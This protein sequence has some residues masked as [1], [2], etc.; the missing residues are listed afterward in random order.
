MAPLK[1]QKKDL[2]LKCFIWYWTIEMD[3]VQTMKERPSPKVL[4]GAKTIKLIGSSFRR[5]AHY[6]TKTITKKLYL[7][8]KQWNRGG[9]RVL[10]LSFIQ[11]SS[12]VFEQFWKHNACIT[13]ATNN[14]PIEICS[15]EHG[16]CAGHISLKFV[17]C[18]YCTLLI[19]LKRM[20]FSERQTQNVKLLRRKVST[21][22]SA[23]HWNKEYMVFQVRKHQLRGKF[24][25][26]SLKTSRFLC[27]ALG[28]HW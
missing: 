5:N 19:L 20:K 16:A 4:F 25:C 23:S 3:R 27:I 28:S 18:T 2:H 8:L 24:E 22:K 10:F 26:G 1:L 6:K 9:F 21:C 12:S 7:T 13:E 15:L 14:S 11:L 17:N